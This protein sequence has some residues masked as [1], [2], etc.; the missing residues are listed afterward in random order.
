ML[1][2]SSEIPWP[3]NTGGHLRSFHLI[4]SFA[5]DYRVRLVAADAGSPAEHIEPFTR[6]GIDVR[7]AI[8]RPRNPAAEAGRAMAAALHREPYVLYRRHDRRA[9]RTTLR[10]EIARERPDVLYLDHLDSFQF[11]RFIPGIPAVLDL[12]NVYSLIARREAADRARHWLARQYLARETRLLD[13][14]EHAAVRSASLVFSV[15][16]LERAHFSRMGGAPVALIENG[17]D[18]A[19]YAA[20]PAGRRAAPPVILFI[21]TL[22]WPPNAAAAR[23]LATEALPAVRLRLPDAQLVLVGRSPGSDVLALAAPGR[24]RVVADA[25]DIVPFL[26]DASMLAVPLEVGGGTRLKILEAFAAGLPV[27]STA[28]GCEGLAGADGGELIVAERSRFADAICALVGNPPAA[29]EMAA[30]ARKL[31]RGRYDWSIIGHRA[32]C[33]VRTM[34][35]AASMRNQLRRAMRGPTRHSDWRGGAAFPG[36][37]V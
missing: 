1:C 23:F 14:V 7:P 33:A 18:C 24:V 15:S 26:R 12:H 21:G 3:L 4:T 37:L 11:V 8:V 6:C 2:V 36:S 29:D 16:D 17:V 30:R 13:R 10:A 35:T 9:V 20:L 19:R 5:A 22:S 31:V 27:V 28:I 25:A 32:R 34:L